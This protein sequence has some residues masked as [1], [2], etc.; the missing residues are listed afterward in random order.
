[1]K[2][3]YPT[4][5]TPLDPNEA[6]GLIPTHITTQFELNEWEQANILDA[7]AWILLARHSS[8]LTISFIQQLHKKM[9]D[10]TWRWAG[11]FRAS[12]KNIGIEH[13]TIPVQ[14][15]NLLDDVQYQ[16]AQNSY[17]FDEMAAR[18]HH[19]LVWI[20]AFPNG[21]GR[22]ARLMTDVLLIS[23]SEPRF[24]WGN[25]NLY[26]KNAVRDQYIQCLR[27]ADKHDYKKLLDFVRS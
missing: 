6:E 9:F 26:S 23:H 16:I 13:I 4:G 21:N 15:K 27:D 3:D 11:E 12:N 19:R 25:T 17:T 2:F 20:H 24:T 22:H 10:K 7:E 5:A 14:L 8:I 18:F 1:M